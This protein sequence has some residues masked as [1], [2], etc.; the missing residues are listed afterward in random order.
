M[1]PRI[2]TCHKAESKVESKAKSKIKSKIESKVKSKGKYEIKSKAESKTTASNDRKSQEWLC[3]DDSWMKAIATSRI[4]FRIFFAPLK[5]KPR[6]RRHRRAVSRVLDAHAPARR[7]VPADVA[8]ESSKRSE[9]ARRGR[10]STSRQ[11]KFQRSVRLCQN[12]AP[13]LTPPCSLFR[14]TLIPALDNSVVFMD[15]I[16][17]RLRICHPLAPLFL[18][19]RS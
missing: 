13:P 3:L 17:G 10:S 2:G 16:R 14:A 19:L 6:R 15:V 12:S 7:D 5:K 8:S 9:R 11:K 4:F 18:T 1:Y